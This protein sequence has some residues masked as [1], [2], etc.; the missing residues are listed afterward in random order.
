M[1]LKQRILKLSQLLLLLQGYKKP[2]HNKLLTKEQ[3]LLPELLKQLKILL[4]DMKAQ[5]QIILMLILILQQLSLPYSKYNR[6]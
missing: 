1:K 4:R 5:D 6:L 3:L 2:K